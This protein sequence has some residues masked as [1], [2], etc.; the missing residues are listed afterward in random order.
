MSVHE[1]FT[2]DDL[3]RRWKVQVD[4]I[5][6]WLAQERRA[7]RGPTLAEAI[8]KRVW[9]DREKAFRTCMVVREDYASKIEIRYVF[10]AYRRRQKAFK[11]GASDGG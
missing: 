5:R 11:D 2:L 1:I 4:T 7:G 6:D 8:V 10:R 3:A 9:V